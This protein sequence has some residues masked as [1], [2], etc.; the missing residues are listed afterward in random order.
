MKAV[1]LAGGTGSRL[2]PM[3]RDLK[4]KQFHA[5]AG[6]RT[7]LQ[8][9]YDRLA[10]L[11]PAD[12]FVATNQ[13]YGELVKKQLPQ[14][15]KENLIIEPAFR[16]TAP[17]I[18]F[19]AHTLAA[20]G[21]SDEVMSVIYADHLIHKPEELEKALMLAQAHIKGG[22]SLCLIAVRAKYPNTNLGY[23]AI[24]Q[25][26]EENED[27]LSVHELERFVEKPDYE[28]ARQ[29]LNS[30][31]Y[32]WNTGLYLWK[33][34]AILDEFKTH[35]PQIYKATQRAETYEK[36]PKISIDYAIMEK[37]SPSKVHVIPADL[38]WN[39][40]G[41]WA[42]LHEELTKTDNENVGSGPH[43]AVDTQGS[44]ILSNSGKLVV[45]YGLKNIIVVDT[46]EALLVMP[47][48]KA[49]E[50]KKIT[51][52]LRRGKKQKFL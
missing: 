1:I 39:D 23:I 29:F 45:T 8:Q 13:Q 7:M 48:D 16:D 41:N 17:C 11:K 42:A 26:L 44:V 21:F 43:L 32:L 46:P 24:G 37:I 2:W 38:G 50:V 6:N 33:V 12:I 35:A 15:K 27:G 51:E 9:T 4:P 31:K 49:G 19:A 40:I 18:A 5:F 52:A 34:S 22:A 20:R 25:Q 14:L 36:S 3:S 28:T 10:F 30:Y 47:K